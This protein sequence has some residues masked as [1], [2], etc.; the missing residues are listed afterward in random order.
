MLCLIRVKIFLRDF[1]GNVYIIEYQK[2]GLPHM[3]FL[4]FLHLVDQFFETSKTD[5]IIC[6]KLFIIETDP[7]E[8][9][10]KII[11]SIML[12]DSCVDINSHL[13]CMGNA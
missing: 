5:E 9:F 12:H 10:I 3:H 11:T 8:K 1:C 4:I 13:I 7:R 2:R 6:V